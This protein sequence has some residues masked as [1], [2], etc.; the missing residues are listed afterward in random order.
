MQFWA[1]RIEAAMESLPDA[2]PKATQALRET[3]PSKDTAIHK[4]SVTF[5]QSVEEEGVV[6]RHFREVPNFQTGPAIC[7]RI[8]RL[9]SRA[10]ERIQG[11]F[12]PACREQLSR[13]RYQERRDERARIARE[14]HDTLLQ[15]FQG[16]LLRFQAASDLLPTCPQE[17]KQKLD[18]AID[19]AAQA[20]TEGR[21]AVQGFHSSPTVTNDLPADLITLGG[22]LAA[23]QTNQKAPTF[24]VDVEG[25]PQE[26]HAIIRDEVYRIAGE[27][28]RN[29]FRHAQANRIEV[30]IHYGAHELRVRVRDDGKGIEPHVVGDG[31]AGH[32]GLHGMH[33]RAK[34]IG[35]NLEVWSKV[36]SGTEIEL[37]IPAL[38]AYAR[39]A[40]QRRSWFARKG[41]AVQS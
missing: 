28:M 34:L 9:I 31:R 6:E 19:L 35:G 20:I 32:W 21:G 41:T 8:R 25:K 11:W 13:E 39:P 30:E 2:N 29:A 27:A 24:H 4:S 12:R 7:V 26:F 38:T 40:R 15:S 17:A 37:T 36:E 14:L 33:E 3:W 1:G 10:T 5:T 18:N 23:D 22:E 16:L